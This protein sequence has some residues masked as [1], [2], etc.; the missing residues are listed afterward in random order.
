MSDIVRVRHNLNQEDDDEARGK[1]SWV[2]GTG[3]GS[4]FHHHD[5]CLDMPLIEQEE[6]L[7]IFRQRVPSHMPSPSLPRVI[8]V[9]SYNYKKTRS[10]YRS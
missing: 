10:P 8:L 6:R 2:M 1:I 9:N 3:Q 7:L 5:E 4:R